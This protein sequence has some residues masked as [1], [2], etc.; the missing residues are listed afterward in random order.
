M[1]D[2]DDLVD[3]DDLA[4]EE[5]LRLRRVHDLLL[6]AGPPAELPPGLHEPGAPPTAQVVQFVLPRRRLAVGLI[7]AATVAA[8]A[9]GGGYVFGHGKA[10]P[11]AFAAKRVVD[12]HAAAGSTALAVLKVAPADSVGNWPMR[13]TVQGLPAQQQRGAYYELWL[14]KDG[15]P[16]VSCGRFRVHGNATTV[17][18]T[19]PYNLR[20]YNGWIVTADVPGGPDPGRVV[21][22]T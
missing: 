12:M 11:A 9:F 10:A 17:D 14:T 3:I 5:E 19:V 6:A 15:K 7:A 20:Q 21:L 8:A 13:M 2:F 18:L 1:T 4:P 22:T 16:A